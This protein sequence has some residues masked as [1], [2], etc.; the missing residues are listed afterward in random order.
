MLPCLAPWIYLAHKKTPPPRTLQEACASGSRVVLGGLRF[1]VSE[2]PLYHRTP[3]RVCPCSRVTPL[4]IVDPH[5]GPIRSLCCLSHFSAVGNVLP[6][7]GRV[8]ILVYDASAR[9]RKVEPSNGSTASRS[10][11]LPSWPRSS[12]FHTS[13]LS[14]VSFPAAAGS[15]SPLPP[16]QGDEARASSESHSG[17]LRSPCHFSQFSTVGNIHSSHLSAFGSILPRRS[18]VPKSSPAAAG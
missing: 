1:L 13:A 16:Q 12:Y 14:G 10:S 17:P 6:R 18:R 9:Y 2:V 7:R 11:S 15:R 4:H 8:L 5:S 3:G